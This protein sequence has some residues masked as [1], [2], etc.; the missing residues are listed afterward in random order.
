MATFIPEWNKVS[1]RNLHVKRVLNGLDDH[2]VVR[3]TIKPGLCPADLFVQHAV[4]G[5][6]AVGIVDTAFALL[7]PTQLFAAQGQRDFEQYLD[8]FR[9]LGCATG[10]DTVLVK[11]MVILWSCSNEQAGE[12]TRRYMG[13]RGIR[14]VSREQ[15]EQMGAE[16]VDEELTGITVEIEHGL[17]AAYFPEVEIAAPSTTRRL[18]HHDN[19]AKLGRFFF[20][21]EQESI[22]KLDLE[23]PDEQNEAA[24]DLSVRLINGVAG[25]GKTLI[26]ISRAL[27]LADLYPDQRLLMLIHNTP[28]VADIKYRLA[29]VRGR[30][31]SNLEISTFYGWMVRRWRKSFGN[32]PQ[33]VDRKSSLSVV[34]SCR[35]HCA[36]LKQSDD[37]LLDEIDFINQVP[38][39]TEVA[40][41]VVNRVGRGFA[42]RANERSQMW[43][44]YQSVSKK[45][46]E[47]GFRMWSDL[48][49][50]V[51]LAENKRGQFPKYRHVLVD[52]AQFF[53]PSSFQ[54]IRQSIEV[55]GQ[56]FLCADPTQG[57]M[58]SRLSWKSVGLEVAGRTRRLRKS[59][60]TT[61]AILEAANSVLAV[62]GQSDGDDYLEPDLSAMIPGTRP[63]LICVD[64]PQDGV[65]RVV[66]EVQHLCKDRNTSPGDILVIY[67]RSSPKGL[68]YEEFGRR[69]GAKNVWWL[70]RDEH[71][72]KP[73]DGY[74]KDYLRIANVDTATGLEGGI[75]FLMGVE[76]LFMDRETVNLSAEE[77]VERIEE[78][79]RKLYMAMTRAGKQ[80]VLVSAES[81]P[82]QVKP[83]FEETI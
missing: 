62:L 77:R 24:K 32:N 52:E 58:K 63:L 78:N 5:W 28:V 26:A 53:A 38:L 15:F 44:L 40:Y 81:I 55:E 54:V 3:R 12:L 80:L 47:S 59:Y 31:P 76:A 16:I 23:M 8:S 82:E 45:L 10:H 70:N 48:A 11:S 13:L 72:K 2:Y 33:I 34:Q 68:L 7:D 74:D 37:Q 36:D 6:L 75:V 51:L 18:F 69:L 60:R 57:F 49:R 39:S 30:L 42:L 21:H 56:L 22:S 67:G 65:D 71:K 25:S 27:M 64:T 19:S 17:L 79:A 20:D 9:R 46:R 43:A 41:Q 83:F 1:G 61:R 73:P 66:N 35:D 29:R 14:L 50:D 4:K